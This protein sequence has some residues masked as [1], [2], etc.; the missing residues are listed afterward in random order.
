M[1]YGILEVAF[2]TNSSNLSLQRDALVILNVVPIWHLS[3]WTGEVRALFVLG[4]Y[5]V[6]RTYH[7]SYMWGVISRAF[8]T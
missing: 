4:V 8:R 3:T 5:F 2:A 1:H 6:F 7:Q